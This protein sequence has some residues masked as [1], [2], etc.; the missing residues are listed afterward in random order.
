M[1]PPAGRVEADRIRAEAECR[2]RVQ[3]G[4]LP[5]G[6]GRSARKS[7]VSA[8][9][10][11]ETQGKGG[12]SATAAV[13]TQGKG[14]VQATTAVETQGKGSVLATTAVGTQGKGSVSATTKVR[15][16]GTG[17]VAPDR[18]AHNHGVLHVIVRAFLGDAVHEV[19]TRVC[20][21]WSA[22][23]CQPHAGSPLAPL[24]SSCENGSGVWQGKQHCSITSTPPP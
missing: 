19:A 10:A 12:V 24:I 11:V 23:R 6:P 7:I 3:L 13:E 9:T 21:V 18:V 5:A 22:A 16:Q 2:L 20:L 8:T 1:T 14:G 4:Q 15:A 17:S